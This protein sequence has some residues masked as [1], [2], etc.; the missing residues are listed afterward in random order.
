[1]IIKGDRAKYEVE[2]NVLEGK[3]YITDEEGIRKVYHDTT[4]DFI[5]DG[6]TDE[7]IED[8]FD[9]LDLDFLREG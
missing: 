2:V 7:Q 6:M 4:G 5:T 8:V 1:M 9:D 3:M